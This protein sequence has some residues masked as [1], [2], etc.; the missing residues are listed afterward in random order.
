[1]GIHISIGISPRE[2]LADWMSFVTELEAEG[3][4]RIWLIDSQLAMKDVYVGLA[5]AAL[6]SSRLELGTGVTNMLTRHPTVTANSISAIA[7]LSGGRAVLGLGAGDSAVYGLG[8]SPSKM[9]EVEEALKFFRAILHGEEGTWE[10]RSFRLAQES[11]PVK[12]Y[13]AVTQEKMCRLAGRL[14]DGAIIMGPAQKDIVARQV[15]WVEA[16]MREAGRERSEVDL[17][18]VATL[19]VG[20]GES[21]VN[22]VASWATG[23]ARLLAHTKDLPASLHGYM[24]EFTRASESYDYGEHLSTRA[25]HRAVISDELIKVLAI[26][27]SASDCTARLGELKGTGIDRFIFPLMGTGRIERLRQLRDEVL[28]GDLV[29][30]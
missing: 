1:M 22:D 30:P 11:P 24:D 3:A 20:E 13:L 19:S 15:E 29:G 5:T 10:G 16:G 26:A 17:S 28:T 12:I 9:A 25:S 6:K 23:Q 18:Y 2:S 8:K 27:G 21:A 4:D 7:E 14:A